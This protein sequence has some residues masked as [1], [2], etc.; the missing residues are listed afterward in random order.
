[1]RLVISR[2]DMEKVFRHADESFPVECCGILAGRKLETVYVVEK[3]YP[4][5]NVLESSY[6]Y[7][8][9]PEEQLKIFKDAEA[10]GLE[11][12]GFYHS[13]PL[14]DAYW[15]SIDEEKSKPWSGYVFLVVS[16]KK[17]SFVAYLRKENQT[18]KIDVKIY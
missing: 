12:I 1:M 15:S 14:T 18:V 3:V 9:D 10:N 6:E 13:H 11:V 2:K 7:L 17:G 4:A 5:R 16:P 8:M